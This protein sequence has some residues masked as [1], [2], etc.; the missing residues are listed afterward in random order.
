M[1]SRRIREIEE[2]IREL[3][4]KLLNSNEMDKEIIRRKINSLKEELRRL[5]RKE[6]E[7]EDDD[8]DDLLA[9]VIGLGIGSIISSGDSGDS[10][11]SGFDGFGGGDSGG[12]GFG[13]GW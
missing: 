5:K 3:E 2:E 4:R 12:G 9:S 10:G 1:G 8:G 11:S 6:E 13:G 7:E